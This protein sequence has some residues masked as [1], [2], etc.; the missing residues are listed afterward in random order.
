MGTDDGSSR[1][2]NGDCCTYHNHQKNP[3]GM[4][5]LLMMGKIRKVRERRM[6]RRRKEGGEL[7]LD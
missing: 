2:A 5:N 6:S 7:G 1:V 4:L 3:P